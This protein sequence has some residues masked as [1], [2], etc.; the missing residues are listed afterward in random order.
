MYKLKERNIE[1]KKNEQD[2]H[3]ENYL[4]YNQNTSR[5]SRLTRSEKIFKENMLCSE[6]LLHICNNIVYNV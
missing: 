3:D 6:T 4:K 1:K 5:K 2:L